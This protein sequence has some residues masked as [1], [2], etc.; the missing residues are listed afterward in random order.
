FKTFRGRFKPEKLE[1]KQVNE[2]P[3]G[4][5]ISPI[6]LSALVVIFG[7]FPNLLAYT[8]IEPAMSAILPGIMEPGQQFSVNISHWHGFNLELWMTIGVI[9]LG[10]LLFL[11]MNKWSQ[12]S[13]YKKERDLFNYVYDSGYDGLIKG[14]QVITRL[15]MTGRLRDYFIYMC[16]FIVLVIGYTM[17][18]YDAFAINTANLSPIDPYMWIL[19]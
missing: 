1:V 2:A 18:R 6:I 16:V 14:S 10:S 15:Q 8:L 19:T 13:F 4:M 7:L 5:L 9:V 17:F 12:S 11:T 3:F